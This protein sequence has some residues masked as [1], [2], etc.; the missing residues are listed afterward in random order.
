MRTS[1]EET[2]KLVRRVLPVGVDPSAVGVVVLER[3]PV[4][5]CD[6]E[7]QP[8][9]RAERMHL[10]A[11]LA[12]NVGRAIRRSVVDDEHVCVG[13]LRAQRVE[14]GGQIVLLVPGRDE[15]ER[16]VHALVDLRLGR[17]H[18]ARHDDERPEFPR[19]SAGGR[20][21]RGEAKPDRDSVRLVD[22]PE[23]PARPEEM[24]WS[25]E[26]DCLGDVRVR[27]AAAASV[28]RSPPSSTPSPR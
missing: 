6:A 16:V 19:D 10:G 27:A 7:S 26:H 11:V 1:C 17:T 2:G 8:Q 22:P 24:Q 23:D 12:C 9:V 25:A 3:P 5:G 21:D 15:D 20:H 18:L 4:A 13:K 28:P 14:H